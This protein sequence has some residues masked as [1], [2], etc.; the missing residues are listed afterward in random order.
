MTRKGTTVSKVM[1]RYKALCDKDWPADVTEGRAEQVC[2]TLVLAEQVERLA[3]AAEK[4]DHPLIGVPI[5]QPKPADYRCSHA[6]C[7]KPATVLMPMGPEGRMWCDE[8][9]PNEEQIT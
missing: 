6:E 1:E 4:A 7:D 8:H 9:R 2:A 5:G 3:D